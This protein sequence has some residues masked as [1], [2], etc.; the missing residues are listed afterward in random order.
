MILA[1]FNHL[2]LLQTDLCVSASGRGRPTITI[3]GESQPPLT[4][5]LHLA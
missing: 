5:E 2:I 4:L 3:S 1:E